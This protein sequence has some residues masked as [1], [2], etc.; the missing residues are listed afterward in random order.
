MG[1]V[2]EGEALEGAANRLVDD[3]PVR[4]NRAEALVLA[5]AVALSRVALGDGD[6]AFERRDDR[7]DGDLA[8]RPGED[9]AAATPSGGVPHPGDSCC[10]CPSRGQLRSREPTLR[11][12]SSRAAPRESDRASPEDW[13]MPCSSAHRRSEEHTSE[14]QSPTY[15]VCRLL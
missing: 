12:G 6:G 3:L 9:V 8:G 11:G 15:L 7:G 14:L 10:R 1:H 2:R 4:A 5:A 13:R